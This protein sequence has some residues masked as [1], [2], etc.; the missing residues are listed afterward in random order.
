MKLFQQLG[1]EIERLWLDQNYNEAVFPSLAAGE[2]AKH[3]LP[4]KLTAWDVLEW[5][6]TNPDLPRQ[7][8]V[9]ARFGDPPITIY[10][11][12]RF[13]VDVYFWFHGT[14]ATHQHGFCG[15]FQVLHGSSIHSWY[16]F[17]R[18]EVI[19]AFCEIGDINL[20]V[21]ELLEIGAVQ[22]IQPGRQYIHSLF[23]LDQPSATIVVRTDRSPLELPQFS[24][25][26]PSLAI[27]PFF[28]QDEL[29]KKLQVMSAL[30]HSNRPEADGLIAEWLASSD[31]QTS[32]HILSGIR[33]LLR[34][35]HLNQMFRPEAAKDRFRAIPIACD[36]PSRCKG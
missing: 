17:E 20:K 36:R 8:D 16:E 23:H 21:C 18:R 9:P 10:S 35:N 12:R 25:H 24:Y 2:L 29:T 7:R 1:A 26:K 34:S 28:E 33:S 19:N 6:I 4:T 27:D 22:E 30:V 14:T 3:A 32:F 11:G 31:F 15:A 13:H 5:A